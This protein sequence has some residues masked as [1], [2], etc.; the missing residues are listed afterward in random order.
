MDDFFLTANCCIGN[1]AS[2]FTAFLL[3]FMPLVAEFEVAVIYVQCPDINEVNMS[4]CIQ[5]DLVR[6]QIVDN[7]F[8]PVL[9]VVP[10][11][12]ITKRKAYSPESNYCQVKRKDSDWLDFY[13]QD[14]SDQ[15]ISFLAGSST[16][17]L[18]SRHKLCNGAGTADV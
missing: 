11:I 1:P 9:A 14:L 5:S 15:A 18:H 2:R 7:K 6:S 16:L 13:I 3:A 8:M 12:E 10:L 17:Q 4:V